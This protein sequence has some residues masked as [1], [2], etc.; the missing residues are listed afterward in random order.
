MLD[1]LLAN[2]F[3]VERVKRPWAPRAFTALGVFR[4]RTSYFFLET[5]SLPTLARRYLAALPSMSLIPFTPFFLPTFFGQAS[6]RK[7][8]QLLCKRESSSRG[9]GDRGFRRETPVLQDRCSVRVASRQ[10]PS[11][12]GT[13]HSGR[14]RRERTAPGSAMPPLALSAPSKHK[15]DN[16]GSQGCAAQTSGPL[17][18]A[19]GADGRLVC[20]K[21]I[22]FPSA[23]ARQRFS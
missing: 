6:G 15:L 17:Q 18:R 5:H 7:T 19:C 11:F 2:P 23:R 13:A 1:C 20:W 12:V 16:H 10:D 14:H 3:G 9:G 8:A 22:G 21:F 4:F